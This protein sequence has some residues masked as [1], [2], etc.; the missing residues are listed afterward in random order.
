MIGQRSTWSAAVT[1]IGAGAGRGRGRRCRA[2]GIRPALRTGLA[3]RLGVDSHLRLGQPDQLTGGRK[4]T[5]SMLCN[6]LH[7]AAAR[8]VADPGGC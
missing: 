8:S 1:E 6:R 2:V 5:L 3:D 4:S 7:V